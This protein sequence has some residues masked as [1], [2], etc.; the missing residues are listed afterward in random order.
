MAMHT[1]ML[2]NSGEHM[3]CHVMTAHGWVLRNDDANGEYEA[4]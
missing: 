1:W 3:S 4:I 2:H